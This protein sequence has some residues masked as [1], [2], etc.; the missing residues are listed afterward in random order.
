VL[1]VSRTIRMSRV[2]SVVL[3]S[4]VVRIEV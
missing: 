4:R 3:V 2:S 1:R